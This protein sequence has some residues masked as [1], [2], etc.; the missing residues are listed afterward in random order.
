MT[1]WISKL[2]ICL[3]AVLAFWPLAAEDGTIEQPRRLIAVGDLHGD[4]DA[5]LAVAEHAGLVDRK[6]RWKGK[7][8]VL[9]QLGDMTDRGPNSLKIIRHLQKL[10]QTAPRKG[11][12][13][14]VL[15]GNHEAMNVTGDLRYV[16]PGEYAAFAT[17]QSDRLRDA[18]WEANRER[19]EAAFAALDPPVGAEEAKRRWYESTPPGMLEHRRAW[20]PGGELGLWAAARPAVVKIGETL[21][22][23]GGLSAERSVEPFASINARISAALSPGTVDR[24]V[25]E[26]PLG[27]L[28]YRGN[29]RRPK[30]EPAPESTAE[31]A[32]EADT[33]NNDAVPA[34]QAVDPR[35]SMEDE[36]TQV[37]A[38]YHAKRLV[39]AHTPSLEGI[40]VSL[41]GRLI[42]V[43]TGMSRHYGG[44]LSF[45]E[46]ID[47]RVIAHQ[48]SSD[49][50]WTSREIE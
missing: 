21:F 13:V 24:S 31:T 23:H 46:F 19:L 26:D 11:G 5:W 39:V 8:T 35:P 34:G 9:V 17:R 32:L 29:V 20:S 41:G 40:A 2:L 50:Q 10:D 27:P 12:R 4:Y 1:R 43:D 18:V 33:A 48:R 16:D 47:G 22:V 49:G 3:A 28:W 38:R 37:L 44:P 42:R 36:L 25:L 45:L 15:L 14:I 6:G 7:D 30:P